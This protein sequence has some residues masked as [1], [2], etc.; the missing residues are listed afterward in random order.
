MVGYC[1]FNLHW[2]SQGKNLSLSLSSVID[3]LGVSFNFII[4]FRFCRPPSEGFGTESK[5]QTKQFENS[6]RRDTPLS[7]PRITEASE[8]HPCTR[9]H[10]AGYLIVPTTRSPRV[11]PNHFVAIEFNFIPLS[12][13]RVGCFKSSQRI[14]LATS[15][16]TD[17]APDYL[18]A[19]T[20]STV[21]ILGC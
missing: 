9:T 4:K 12:H 17:M 8:L 20:P 19:N 3:L 7:P 18:F 10:L 2:Q 6:I 11:P 15:L 13:K 21:G 16:D 1:N 14:E 5:G